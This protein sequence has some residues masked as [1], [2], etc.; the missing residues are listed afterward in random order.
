MERNLEDWTKCTTEIL[1]L[2]NKK[3]P[4]FMRQFYAEKDIQIILPCAWSIGKRK[5]IFLGAIT[6]S[7]AI[8][9]SR[10]AN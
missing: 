10:Y 4:F 9:R 1:H 2:H 5:T 6:N 3:K 7:S 8:T